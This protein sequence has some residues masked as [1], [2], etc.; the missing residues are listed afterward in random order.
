VVVVVEVLLSMAPHHW[1]L[2]A[3]VPGA[4]ITAAA[5]T[6]SLRPTAPVATATTRAAAV[7]VAAGAMAAAAGRA[8][9]STAA[10]A[11]AATAETATTVRKE[12]TGAVV[13]ST[14][15]PAPA[16]AALAAAAGVATAAG[17]GGANGY[18]GGG[19]G[20][21]IDSSAIAGLT[22]ISGIASPDDLPNGEI[23][24]AQLASFIEQPSLTAAFTSNVT[25]QVAVQGTPPL[26]FQ[27]YY[28]GAPLSDNG[29]YIG[30]METNLTITDFLPGDTGNYTL[31]VT[32][33]AGS[34]TSAVATLN[35][36]NPVITS[37]PQSQS[38]LGGA[39]VT[40][41]AGITGQQ[42]LN[43][44]WLL[45]GTNLCMATTDPLI[46]SNVLVNQSGNYSLLVSNAYSLVLSSNATLSVQPMEISFLSGNQTVPA[47]S[48]PQF[49]VGVNGAQPI[50]YQWLFNGTNLPNSDSNIL[51]VANVQL[52]QAGPYSVIVTNYY[53]MVTS[54]VVS[55]G[56]LPLTVTASNQSIITWP[57][58]SVTFTLSAGGV[59]PIN[60]QWL[61]NGTNPIPGND[62][63]ALVL[64][65][66]QA[67][68]FGNYSVIVTN[69]YE[70]IT[71][72]MATLTLSQVAVWGGNDGE[73]NLIAG[74]TNVVAIA[75]GYPNSFDCLV[76]RSNGTA[77]H[78]P[79]PNFVVVTNILSIGGGGGP[80][81]V[82]ERN[83]KMAEWVQ[84][85]DLVLLSGFTNV[86]A[87]PPETIYSVI[88]LGAN[89]IPI[90][91]P[92]SASGAQTNALTNV[93]S[94]AQGY[95]YN[96]ALRSDGTVVGWGDGAPG[97][98]VPAGLSNV[99]AIAAGYYTAYAVKSD[100]TVAAWGENIGG[101]TTYT[102]N[103]TDV[104]AV[105]AGQ[106]HALALMAN[107]TVTA[108]G[109]NVY[110]G[111]NVPPG[112]TNVIAIAAGQ[113]QSMAL[114]GNG[115]PVLNVPLPNP[116]LGTNGFSFS[117][118]SQSGRVYMLQY[119]NSLTA[120][121]WISLPLV[122]GTGGPLL[123]TDPSPTNSQRFYRVRKW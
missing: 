96:L 28:N 7:V 80:F 41:S 88:A 24:I 69:G 56:V 94:I 78:W 52:N 109:R 45:N 61:F 23:I 53:G 73:T 105:A 10:V 55:L 42:P 35:I 91:G 34:I 63:N 67:S 4:H 77:I 25:F 57:G 82:T 18:G 102:T 50:Y 89:G 98:N 121:N 5:S 51:T 65:N 110:G 123:L 93:V 47:A 33:Y 72:S 74:L 107:G 44:Q 114:I 3:A 36:L 38:V 32:N 64:P 66:L 113:Y 85:Y 43:Y 83:G 118:P 62:T 14:A 97:E 58:N 76:L 48:N 112:L 122:P 90:F 71:S 115:P 19:G 100:G 11:A 75:A 2:P 95:E 16:A 22:E 49:I 70:S 101:L 59:P 54:S 99:V 6:G 106:Y 119:Q 37:Q 84:D 13:S 79:F 68:Q 20:S 17:G 21:I 31:V 46:L 86:V 30:S 15:A 60:Y 103:L 120:T 108:W 12:V 87:M 92:G 8:W 111:T 29:H 39:T 117:V 116:I 1:S 9:T 27:W 104:I 40:F 81:L 26:S